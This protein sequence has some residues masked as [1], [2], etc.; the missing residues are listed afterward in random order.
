MPVTAV[1]AV[2]GDPS[3]RMCVLGGRPELA[4]SLG[5]VYACLVTLFFG[6]F[7]RTIRREVSVLH[8]LPRVFVTDFAVS[9]CGTMLVVCETQN[10]VLLHVRIADGTVVKRV[11]GVGKSPLQF[12][13]HGYLRVHA[14]ADGRVLVLDAVNARVQVLTPQLDFVSCIHVGKLSPSSY[15]WADVDVVIVQNEAWPPSVRVF[16]RANGSQFRRVELLHRDIDLNASFASFCLLPQ[17]RHW[18]FT[19]CEQWIVCEFAENGVF[20]RNLDDGDGCSSFRAVHCSDFDLIIQSPGRF[21]VFSPDFEHKAVV[22][23]TRSWGYV[24][25]RVH[26]GTLIMLHVDC[27]ENIISME[28]AS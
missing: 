15:F 21:V 2:L 23:V 26:D 1:V 6:T 17:R 24:G 9:R 16:S 22:H 25:A 8:G 3:R 14:P 19:K 4:R 10:S 20:R 28:V 13:R 18:A 27:D 5:C 11:G 7:Q 12:G